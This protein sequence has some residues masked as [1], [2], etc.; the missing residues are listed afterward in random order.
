MFVTTSNILFR[1][2]EIEIPDGI[3]QIVHE[4]SWKPCFWYCFAFPHSVSSTSKNE[5]CI[6]CQLWEMKE[7]CSVEM[8]IKAVIE[9]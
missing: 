9:E 6:K 3:L 5:I 8:L 7:K 4:I 1:A 2:K